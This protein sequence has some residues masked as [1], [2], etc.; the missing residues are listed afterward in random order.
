MSMKVIVK[1]RMWS[2]SE[3]KMVHKS[4]LT[5]IR[6]KRKSIKDNYSYNNLLLDTCYIKSVNY[7]IVRIKYGGFFI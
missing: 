4:L 7:D 6:V 5:R 3:Y 2:S 1:V